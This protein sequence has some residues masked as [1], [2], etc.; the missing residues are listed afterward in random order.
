MMFDS[1]PKVN[2]LEDNEEGNFQPAIPANAFLKDYLIAVQ[3][4][5]TP[6]Q[7]AE[8]NFGTLPIIGP[9][10]K[11]IRDYEDRI[12]YRDADPR[13]RKMMHLE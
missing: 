8:K 1:F 7:A 9:M 10:I 12:N 13:L 5:L 11:A 2:T 6:V 3:E 4:K